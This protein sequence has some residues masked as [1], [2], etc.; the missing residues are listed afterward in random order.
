MQASPE[1]DEQAAPD[2]SVVLP[3]CGRVDL[4]DRCLDALMR[5]TFDGRRFEVLVVD[6]N[7]RHNTRQLVAVWRASAGGRGPALR[8]LPNTGTRSPTATRNLGWRNARAALIAFTEDDTVPSPNWLQQGV[9]AVGDNVDAVTGRVEMP[10][11]GALTDF[12][13]EARRLDYAEFS[14]ANCFCR[15]SVLDKLGGFDE[16]FHS[17]WREDL[18]FRL[19]K[20]HANIARTEHALVIRPM[21]PAPWG[22]SVWQLRNLVFEALLYK[23]HPQLYRQKIRATPPWEDY[24]IVTALAVFLMGLGTANAAIGLGGAVA[25]GVPT[26]LRCRRRLRGT[27]R[28]L[29]HVAEMVVTSA[30]IPPMAVFWRLAGAV[31]FRVRFA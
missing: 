1:P 15:K 31:R 18:H 28:A 10:T 3:A 7:P 11:T 20:A 21:R 13:R 9:G 2:V 8:Y 24:S 27:S 29:A 25:W 19:L 30:L 12:Q 23:N 14:T 22:D 5:Q 26:A 16:R 17:G 6:D 4:L